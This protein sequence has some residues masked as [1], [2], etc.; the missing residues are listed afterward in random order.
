MAWERYH[1]MVTAD[2]ERL[3]KVRD[4]VQWFASPGNGLAEVYLIYEG[5]ALLTV[6]VSGVGRA[7]DAH[8]ASHC[9]ADAIRERTRHDPEI[10][11]RISN[12]LM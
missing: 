2:Q 7:H 8:R 1:I 3:A 5:P 11:I 9:I 10:H 6:G 4:I 12:Q